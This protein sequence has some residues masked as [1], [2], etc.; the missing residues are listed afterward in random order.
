MLQ[1]GQYGLI[2]SVVACATAVIPAVFMIVW[3]GASVEAADLDLNALRQ[4]ESCEFHA[5]KAA[6]EAGIPVNL[7]RAVA[8]V[9]AG[10]RNDSQMSAWPWS[11]N[12][13]GRGYRFNTKQ[14]ALDQIRVLIDSGRHN[15]DVGCFQINY[16]WHGTAFASPETMLDPATNA[17]FAAD[18]LQDLYAEF[19]SWRAAVGAYHSR[20][21]TL[22]TAYLARIEGAM[23]RLSPEPH[24]E[25]PKSQPGQSDKKRGYALLT[26][27]EGGQTSPGSLVPISS[28]NADRRPLF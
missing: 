3:C 8:E 19:G 28:S 15:F 2:Q 1:R 26:G 4:S 16:R 27:G 18:F 25:Q 9:E 23:A 7:M 17:R 12:A 5:I 11:I 6:E 24:F 20:T 10:I 21:D 22:A 14:S 13:A